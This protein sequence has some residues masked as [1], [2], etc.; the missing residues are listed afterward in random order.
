MMKFLKIGLISIISLVLIFLLMVIYLSSIQTYDIHQQ[1]KHM[2]KL[3]K[4]YESD[5]FTPVSD[6]LFYDFELLETIKLNDIQYLASHNSYKK[7]GSNLGHF[8][9]GLGSNFNEARAMNYANQTLTNQL[10]SGIRSFEFDVRLRNDTFM[11]THVPLVDNSSVAPLLDLA[12]DEINLYSTYNPNHFPIIIL[13]EIKDD[14]MMLDPSLR[15]I[16]REELIALNLLI[17][18][19]FGQNL[20][21]P[22]DMINGD[23]SLKSSI[24][25]NG[26]PSVQSL[27]GKVM[28]VLHAG[29]IVESYVDLD[30][31]LHT[32]SMFPSVYSN[33]TDRH[34]TSFIIENNPMSSMIPTWISQNFM[35]RT[36]IDSELIII[37]DERTQG[38]SSGAQILTSDYTAGRKDI[39]D[40]EIYY[41]N[42]SQ[43]IRLRD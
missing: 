26:W 36:R 22:S 19:T 7:K 25:D 27:L 17:E 33:Q 11:L 14:W 28:F 18:E 4:M 34:Y 8:F 12:L 41:F 10:S 32:L 30:E 37:N 39:K 43:T 3:I 15:T 16:G 9:V 23:L 31:S 40:D 2:D 42:A 5:S 13:M 6:T 1:K 38:I 20:V 24:E 21:R 29:S 35:V